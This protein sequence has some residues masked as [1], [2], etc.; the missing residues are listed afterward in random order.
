VL[1][2]AGLVLAAVCG[3]GAHRREVAWSLLLGL[4]A[5]L[6]GTLVFFRPPGLFP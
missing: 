1:V 5:G 3:I 2:I 6:A 4:V